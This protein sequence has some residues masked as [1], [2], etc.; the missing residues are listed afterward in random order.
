MIITNL[1]SNKHKI[2]NW[3]WT[4]KFSRIS[5][6]S[7][8]EIKYS[9]CEFM[10]NGCKWIKCATKV[11]GTWWWFL[12]FMGLDFK[13]YKFSLFEETCETTRGP[14]TYYFVDEEF[15]RPSLVYVRGDIESWI[16]PISID[17][18]HLNRSKPIIFGSNEF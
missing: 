2:A 6:A 8:I 7:K 9:T 4:N 3:T 16:Q 15:I 14:L 13:K 17:P 12:H 10:R 11:R 1:H 18:L 5:E